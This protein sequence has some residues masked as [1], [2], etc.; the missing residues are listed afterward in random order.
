MIR[1]LGCFKVVPDLELLAEEDWIADED[2]RVDTSFI[3]TVLN[4]F[5]ESALEMMLKFSDMSED[6]SLNVQLDAVTIGGKLSENYLKTLYALGY[7]RAV[8]IECEQ[9]IQF[10]PELTA[11]LIAEYVSQIGG[12][13]VVIM[14]KQSADG[15]N[16]KTPLLT[17]EQLGWPCIT[18]VIG[19][20]AMDDTWIRVTNRVD[21][22]ICTQRVKL[23]CVLTVGDAPCSYLRVPTLKDR[24]QKGKKE[25]QVYTMEDLYIKPNY[26]DIRPALQLQKL[27]AV[28]KVRAGVRIEGESISEKANDLYQS[29]LKGRLEKL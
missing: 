1:L 5:D 29:Y 8:R 6:L 11:G 2:N 20:E 3:K 10:W 17:A 21:G 13:D 14:G 15:E 9:E 27:E 23:P 22:G 26:R 28:N 12:Q 16:G 4:C 7:N 19:I 18:Q 25:I 24:M